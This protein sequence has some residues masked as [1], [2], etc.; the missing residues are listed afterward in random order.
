MDPYGKFIEPETLQYKRL[1]P[2]PA[3]RIWQYLTES[4]K[5][6]KWFS[7]GDVEPKVG[8]K[9][10]HHFYHQKLS[11]KN[12]PFPEKYKDL[13]EGS[14][15]SGTVTEWDPP[16]TLSYTWS[17]SDGNSEVTFELIPQENDK[18]LLVLTHKRLG[19]DPEILSGIGAGWHTHLDILRDRLEG[20][21]PDGFWGMHMPR[22]EEYRSRIDQ[23]KE[24]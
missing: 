8:G 7:G 23:M 16:H 6:E 18:V 22:E 9:V 21:E 10:E 20:V 13:K 19:N 15:E 12:D 24:G 17:E 14:Y 4:D 1:L 3:E 5:K 2:G 11:S